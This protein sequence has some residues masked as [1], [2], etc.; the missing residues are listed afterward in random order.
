MA[1]IQL[2][3]REVDLFDAVGGAASKHCSPAR[4]TK[5]NEGKALADLNKAVASFK[6]KAA[7]R[8]SDAKVIAVDHT[9]VDI[10]FDGFLLSITYDFN[11]KW[12]LAGLVAVHFNRYK[13]SAEHRGA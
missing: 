2:S 7:Y 11:N 10:R 12:G 9:G 13:L 6:R 8:N 1:R 5:F 3:D 4:K